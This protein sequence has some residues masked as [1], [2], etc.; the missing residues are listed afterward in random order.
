MYMEFDGFERF[1]A[2]GF[3][4]EK[5]DGQVE[6][7]AHH[8]LDVV[9]LT[10]R[11]VFDKLVDHMLGQVQCD[12][13]AVQATDDQGNQCS[14]QFT[15]VGGDGVSQV[16]NDF[17]GNSMPSAY[18]FFRMAMRVSSDGTCRSASNPT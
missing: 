7:V 4:L 8:F 3:A 2:S 11:G 18:I 6:V 10:S 16:F 5:F 14:F 12:G 17:S 13:F 15:H 9:M 1:R